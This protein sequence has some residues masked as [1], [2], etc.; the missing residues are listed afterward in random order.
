M[1]NA[2]AMEPSRQFYNF[3]NTKPSVEIHCHMTG[4]AD[5]LQL[6]CWKFTSDKPTFYHLPLAW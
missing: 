1:V 4:H 2:V 6:C 5:S 3:V